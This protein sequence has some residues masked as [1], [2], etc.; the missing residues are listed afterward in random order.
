MNRGVSGH[1]LKDTSKRRK[2]KYEKAEER[3]REEQKKEET[4]RKIAQLADLEASVREMKTKVARSEAQFDQVQSF[5]NLGLIEMGEDGMPKV[6]VDSALPSERESLASPERQGEQI[7]SLANRR[8]ARE[9]HMD[10]AQIDDNES[11]QMIEEK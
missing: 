1:L 9:F 3:R 6:N 11:N 2:G 10:D 5:I 7:E 8:Q 4:E